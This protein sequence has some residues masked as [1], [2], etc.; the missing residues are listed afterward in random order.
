MYNIDTE[1]FFSNTY[2]FI[3]N[4]IIPDSKVIDLGCGTG[5]LMIKLEQEKNC[6][7]Q[8]IEIDSKQ[9]QECLKKGLFVYNGDIMEGITDFQNN[10]FDYAI[11]S[12]VVSLSFP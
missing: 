3:L 9:V 6:K 5:N 11:L 2:K 4:Y 7:V 1:E 10:R 8:G 12:N